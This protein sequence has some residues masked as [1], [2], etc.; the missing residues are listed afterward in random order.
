M[1]RI[2]RLGRHRRHY[3]HVAAFYA[4]RATTCDPD[5]P[6]FSRLYGHFGIYWH[7]S[8]DERGA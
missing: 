4:E 8:F 6:G 7:V 5:A 2:M 1:D 3:S